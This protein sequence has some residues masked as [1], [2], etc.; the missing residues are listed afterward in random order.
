QVGVSVVTPPILCC[1]AALWLKRRFALG[2]GTVIIGIVLGIAVAACS[3]RDF[4]RL[5]ER[6]ARESERKEK[7]H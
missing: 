6:K 7:W 4:L 5:T 1:F 3:L 2:N